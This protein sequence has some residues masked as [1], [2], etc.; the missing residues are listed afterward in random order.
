MTPT[1]RYF[2]NAKDF[3]TIFSVLVESGS[4]DFLKLPP[5]KDR[6]ARDWSDANG[7]DVDVS[8]N[9]FVNAREITLNCAIILDSEAD[10][11]ERYQKFLAEWRTPGFKRIQVTELGLRSFYCIY[12]ASETFRRFTRVRLDDIGVNETKIACKFSL[13]MV[14]PDPNLGTTDTFIVNESG[15]FLIT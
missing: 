13:T 10:F 1:G 5:A 15:K 11:W 14:E 9:A 2:I 8:K 12:K 3:W 6:I 4:D 7:L